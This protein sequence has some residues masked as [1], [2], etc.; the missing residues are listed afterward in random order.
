MGEWRNKRAINRVM[1][2]WKFQYLFRKL[3]KLKK[4]DSQ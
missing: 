4:F 2:S 3:R 1:I